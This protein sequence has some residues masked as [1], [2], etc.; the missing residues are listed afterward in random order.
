MCVITLG[1]RAQTSVKTRTFT[2]R[3][4]CEECKGRIENAADIKGVKICEWNP[5]TKVASVTY[6]TLKTDLATIQS[7]IA[8]RGYDAGDIKASDKSYRR[9]PTCCKYRDG[10]CEATKK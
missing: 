8:A 9:L 1:M 3:G 2:V 7:A 6:D 10:D 5:K 4:N